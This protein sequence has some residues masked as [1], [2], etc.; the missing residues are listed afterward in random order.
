MH[1]EG[2][3]VK[4]AI[5]AE[6]MDLEAEVGHRFGA[7][8]YLVI[9]DLE[10]MSFEAIPN[11]GATAQRGAGVQAVVLVISKD[12]RAVLTGYCGPAIRRQLLDAGIDVV[13][14][15]SGTVGEVVGKYKK[16]DLQGDE[17][18]EAKAAGRSRRFDRVAI[19]QALKSAAKQFYT[20]LPV[21]IGV[22]L[23]IGLFEAFVS[24]D[25]LSS[26]FS[27]SPALD[28]LWGACFG[29]IFAGNPISSYVIGGELMENGV[30]MFAVTALILT[31]V[32]VGLVQLPA[33]VAA[34]GKRFAIVRTVLCFVLSIPV[35]MLT[36]TI[37]NLVTR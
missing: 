13:T 21:L 24:K 36:V 7:S 26:I 12:V 18:A 1:I 28:T 6:G 10:T 20:L 29:S 23:L 22:V 5:S 25:V 37:L 19:V 11:P 9:V 33:E 15:L 17:S 14:D 31:W 30:S 8:Q 3:A 4:I 16:G 27:G 2:A 32:T 34:L 35:A